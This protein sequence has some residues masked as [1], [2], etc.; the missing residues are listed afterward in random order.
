VPVGTARKGN[1]MKITI[2]EKKN[3]MPEGHTGPWNP[4]ILFEVLE[5]DI[6]SD[7]EVYEFTGCRVQ[8][9]E[10]VHRNNQYWSSG[11][12]FNN[13]TDGNKVFLKPGYLA[14]KK[15]DGSGYF[16]SAENFKDSEYK[17]SNWQE[18]F[19]TSAMGAQTLC[20][21]Q[22]TTFI[23]SPG[24]F[25]IKVSPNSKGVCISSTWNDNIAVT[26]DVDE[27]PELINILK[28]IIDNTVN[29]PEL[30]IAENYMTGHKAMTYVSSVPNK[31]FTD[32]N[33]LKWSVTP[34]G[35]NKIELKGHGSPVTY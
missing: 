19:H 4:V 31:E 22:G 3:P 9:K 25:G 11:Q 24:R 20:Y 29:D 32:H 17:V 15:R 6:A 7:Q 18:R 12:G 23:K 16:C 8:K 26:I 33:D 28:T 5:L 27:V 14:V 35:N 30:S 21:R 1:K 10:P 34:Y 13:G 2:Y